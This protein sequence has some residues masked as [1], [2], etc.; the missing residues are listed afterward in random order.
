[1]I[2][3]R[4]GNCLDELDKIQEE[5]IDLCVTDCPYHIVSGGCSNGAYGNNKQTGGIFLKRTHKGNWQGKTKHIS[6][7]GIFNDMDSTTYARQGKLFKHNEIKF[8]EW[9]PK[10]YRVMKTKSHIYI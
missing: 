10:L 6:L 1:M 7:C 5:S 9:L 3:L 8:N 4:L 2:D